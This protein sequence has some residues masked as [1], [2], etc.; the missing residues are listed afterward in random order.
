MILSFIAAV[1]AFG[2]GNKNMSCSK[3]LAL[4]TAN[5]KYSVET[6]EGDKTL[7]MLESANVESGNWCLIN[8]VINRKKA[9]NGLNELETI[10][11]ILRTDL[12][13]L[14]DHSR[15]F[16]SYLIH[17]A[18]N[19]N[20]VDESK[21]I[22]QILKREVILDNHKKTHL[23]KVIFQ[24]AG[25]HNPLD[26]N[27]MLRVTSALDEIDE[28]KEDFILTVLYSSIPETNFNRNRILTTL[29][30]KKTSWPRF[31]G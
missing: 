5:E 30:D 10:K 19:A 27:R 12:N 6:I 7:K 22:A 8:Q 20:E 2:D 1:L 21:W 4:Q 9:M 17:H 25:M 14:T 13:A 29:E 18:K 3:E 24:N 11:L 28:D 26:D 23:M 16:V 31:M 15:E